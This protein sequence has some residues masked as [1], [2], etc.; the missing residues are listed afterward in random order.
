[1]LS[2]TN[3]AFWSVGRT[4]APPQTATVEKLVAAKLSSPSEPLRSSTAF[5][6][7]DCNFT[8]LK[9][10]LPGGRENEEEGEKVVLFVLLLYSTCP[11]AW[12]SA[13]P[14]CPGITFINRKMLRAR[15]FA[16]AGS[17]PH[18][19][20]AGLVTGTPSNLPAQLGE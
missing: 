11:M 7:A 9:Q 6:E 2:H 19:F 5:S 18:T 12:V 8:C 15:G 16:G 3:E 20:K 17:H 13:A 10:S 4:S 1:M 14:R